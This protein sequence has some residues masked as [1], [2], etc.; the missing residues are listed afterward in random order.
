LIEHPDLSAALDLAVAI[1]SAGCAVAICRGPDATLIP[2]RV[3]RSVDSSLAQW[4]SV[5]MSS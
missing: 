3:A 4:S 5:P 2:P 1:R